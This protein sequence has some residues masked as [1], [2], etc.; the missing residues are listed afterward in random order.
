[1]RTEQRVSPVNFS[2]DDDGLPNAV[3]VKIMTVALYVPN[4]LTLAQAMV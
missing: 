3:L 2:P 1:M 4:S